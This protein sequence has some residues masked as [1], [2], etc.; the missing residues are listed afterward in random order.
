MDQVFIVGDRSQGSRELVEAMLAFASSE[1]P[2]PTSRLQ[3]RRQRS[4]PAMLVNDWGQGTRES[5]TEVV[6]GPKREFLLIYCGDGFHVV[7]NARRCRADSVVWVLSAKARR[8]GGDVTDVNDVLRANYC[9]AKNVIVFVTDAANEDEAHECERFARASLTEYGLLGDERTV[10][11]S[12]GPLV[13]KAGD[14]RW[15]EG[16]G[17]L[18]DALEHECPYE[19]PIARPKLLVVNSKGE[20]NGVATVAGVVRGESI[21]VGDELELVRSGRRAKVA[22]LARFGQAADE[23]TAGNRAEI[24]LEGLDT[25]TVS[26]GETLATP[27]TV[28]LVRTVLGHV[29]ELNDEPVSKRAWVNGVA[30]EAMATLDWLDERFVIPR[31]VRLVFDQPTPWYRSNYAVL[32]DPEVRNASPDTRLW[33]AVFDER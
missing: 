16:V 25:R 5:F 33:L 20:S 1:T 22:K 9:G 8:E 2:R 29:C 3:W 17:Q 30:T 10:V 12:S 6:R 28:E 14:V 13:V 19:E 21:R 4:E 32:Y 26:F 11:F 31:R 7:M 24:Q 15:R 18:F 23:I 27:G